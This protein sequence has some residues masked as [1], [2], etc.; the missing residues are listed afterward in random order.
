MKYYTLTNELEYKDITLE[1]I[2]YKK[3]TELKLLTMIALFLILLTFTSFEI[4]RLN[5]RLS[6]SSNEILKLEKNVKLLNES[7]N[8]N[9]NLANVENYI[10][11]I[12][13]KDKSQIKRQMRLES[14]NTLSN[15]A[16]NYNNL[17]GM[18][19]ANKRPQL[20]KNGK[21]RIYHHWTQSVLDMYLYE[22][23]Y[24]NKLKGYA[25]DP[26]YLIKIAKN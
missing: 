2:Y 4:Y 26:N 12:P 20:G 16:R 17:F 14:S 10:E 6:S 18:K 21:Y 11:S 23:S 1:V 3:Q 19:T 25:E 15:V 5:K 7:E 13:F 8:N 22:L 24:G 9:F